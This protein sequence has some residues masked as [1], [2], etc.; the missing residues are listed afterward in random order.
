MRASSIAVANGFTLTGDVGRMAAMRNH[1]CLPVFAFVALATCAASARADDRSIVFVF[2]PVSADNAQ[3]AAQATAASARNWLKIP[4]AT[5]EIRRP[6]T[7]DSQELSKFMGARD[8][9]AALIDA[10]RASSQ[11]GLMGFLNALDT[12]TYAAARHP[13]KRVVVAVVESPALSGEAESR[14][15]QAIDFCRS[16]LVRV[17]V[18]DPSPAGPPGGGQALKLLATATGGILISDPRE[19]EPS[20]LV[21]AP[22]EK[23]GS[24]SD[25]AQPVSATASTPVHARLIR[26]RSQW[27]PG[28]INSDLGPMHGAMLVETPIAV[29]QV[30]DKNGS[31][32]IRALLTVMVKNADGKTVWQAKKEFNLKGPS[33]RLAERRAGSLYFVRD[34]QLPGG[35]Y[36]IEAVAQDLNSG[37]SW[38]FSEPLKASS[39]LPGFSLSDAFFVRKLNESADKF[40]GDQSLSYEGRALA[41]LLDPS[42][43]SAQPFDLE[44]Y[45]VMYPDTRGG[46]PQISIEIQRDGQVVGRSQ[47]AFNDSIRDTTKGHDVGMGAVA[48]MGEAKG[49]FPYVA[50][51]RDATFSPGQYEAMVTVRQD[52]QTITRS[53]PFR[54]LP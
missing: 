54:V 47:V 33:R 14:L 15:K 51:I 39:N 28:S 45:F 17:T 3:A 34:V 30:D 29:L 21:V 37:K 36:T 19:L 24:E 38:N 23:A 41:P 35:K 1:V 7:R 22:V 46:Q 13:G 4:G 44:L 16:N 2:G 48:G 40:E 8:V 26:M 11:I 42:F 43:H 18:I 50:A 53:V 20:L 49:Q 10:A 52:K 6:G 25:A 27:K 5:A 32:L 12:A 31:Y 9:E